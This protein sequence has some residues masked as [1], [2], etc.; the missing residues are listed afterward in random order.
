M[1]QRPRDG[2]SLYQTSGQLADPAMLVILETKA[3]QQIV[4]AEPKFIL[5]NV[6]Q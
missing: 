1:D 3:L 5:G 6:V 2:G 4:V